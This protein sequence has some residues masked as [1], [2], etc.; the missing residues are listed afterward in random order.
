MCLV[1]RNLVDNLTS[2]ITSNLVPGDLW[3]PADIPTLGWWDASDESTIETT[4]GE[5]TQ[6]NDQKA[7]YP[8]L[9]Q[10]VGFGPATGT[11]TL[12]DL[13][14]LY[15]DGTEALATYG[16]TFNIPP[17]GNFSVFQLT[18]VSLPLENVADGMFSMLCSG[19]CTDWQFVGGVNVNDFNGRIVANEV[20]GV[21][22][23]FTPAMGIGPGL[24]NVV[25]NFDAQTITA[26]YCGVARNETVA[27]TVK[28]SD[29]QT[30]IVMS[31]RVGTALAGH[32]GE[33]VIIEDTSETTRQLVEGSLLWKWGL[34]NQ[35][36]SGHPYKVSPPR[37]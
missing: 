4:S 16:D 9:T 23:N 19:V 26:Y 29:P 5:V 21:N 10:S 12:N 33:T 8:P 11:H 20:G 15:Y 31:N 13:N 2:Y 28:V 7:G 35:L 14:M 30:F 17:S 18:E 36:P 1:T 34:D 22:T 24:Y 32:V 3:T 6:L 25:F 37:T 27:Y